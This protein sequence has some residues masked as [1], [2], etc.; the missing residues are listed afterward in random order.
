[1]KTIAACLAIYIVLLGLGFVLTGELYWVTCIALMLGCSLEKLFIWLFIDP[2]FEKRQKLH[3]IERFG[4]PQPGQ[5]N[6]SIYP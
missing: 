3:L 6:P 2:D 4:K 1:M 5:N